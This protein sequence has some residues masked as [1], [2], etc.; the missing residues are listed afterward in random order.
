MFHDYHPLSLLHSSLAVSQ[1]KM[2]L[3]KHFFR[4]VVPNRGRRFD[5]D[6]D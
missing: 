3:T 6:N 2:D 4:T 1:K 5:D